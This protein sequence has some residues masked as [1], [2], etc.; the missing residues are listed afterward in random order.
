VSVE[1]A[2]LAIPVYR[3]DAIVCL[4]A[5]QFPDGSMAWAGFDAA[6]D[7]VA[8]AV[9]R[10]ADGGILDYVDYDALQASGGEYHQ[11]T[12]GSGQSLTGWVIDGGIEAS[13][14]TG[15]RFR[16]FIMELPGYE[17]PPPDPQFMQAA[18]PVIQRLTINRVETRPGAIYVGMTIPDGF[19][20][21]V[22]S[23]AVGVVPGFDALDQ[24]VRGTAA[25][26]CN[27]EGDT[28]RIVD[29]MTQDDHPEPPPD[30]MPP[31]L[32]PVLPAGRD[33]PLGG[34]S[35]YRA[36]ED[37][38][39]ATTRWY[40][41]VEAPYI[42]QWILIEATPTMTL[43]D[44]TALLESSPWFD[45]TLANP[46]D[47]SSDLRDE[48]GLQWVT[49]LLTTIGATDA[50]EKPIRGRGRPDD[51]G[52]EPVEVAFG[53]Q[54]LG[55][56]VGN[57]SA[58][59]Y[60][61]EPLSLVFLAAASGA[62]VETVDIDGVTLGVVIGSEGAVYSATANCGGISITVRFDS[63]NPSIPWPPPE[64]ALDPIRRIA[65]ELIRAADC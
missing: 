30:P 1:D 47:G 22:V 4:D 36:W 29:W 41:A 55:R 38:A 5:V 27:I 42:A 61:G 52:S 12:I 57:L 20:Q 14:N 15:G 28:F 59:L 8:R 64:L 19:V 18:A 16:H 3:D 24:P 46:L 40:A 48:F 11:D 10:N 63:E 7:L 32:P 50:V 31:D 9:A 56:S 26:F 53:H 21:C 62:N 51:F 65:I 43:D 33:M 6:G 13:V 60:E 25:T 17:L 45:Q 58:Y 49:D 23:H 44:I 34:D 39:G 2:A 37:L 35:T 54:R